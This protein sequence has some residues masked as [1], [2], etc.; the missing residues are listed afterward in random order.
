MQQNYKDN[1][2]SPTLFDFQIQITDMFLV[3]ILA[4]YRILQNSD[5]LE[6]VE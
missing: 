1:Q 6:N 4:L 3:L 2:Q 5:N